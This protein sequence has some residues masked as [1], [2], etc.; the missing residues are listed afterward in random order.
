[1]DK[2]L[3]LPIGFALFIGVSMAIFYVYGLEVSQ[4]PPA[5]IMIADVIAVLDMMFM[6]YIIRFVYIYD[7]LHP[8]TAN[9][10]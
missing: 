5:V 2:T 7:K 6:V 8:V 4:V 1:M 9:N 10:T 3:K